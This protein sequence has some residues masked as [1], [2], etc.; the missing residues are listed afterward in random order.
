MAVEVDNYNMRHVLFPSRGSRNCSAGGL[1]TECTTTPRSSIVMN[2]TLSYSFYI[3]SKWFNVSYA[4][5]RST[6][7]VPV[8]FPP[9]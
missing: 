9:R 4:S 1:D 5:E 2:S 6:N 7:V 3:I 8:I